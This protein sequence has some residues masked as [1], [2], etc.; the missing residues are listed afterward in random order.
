MC[1]LVVTLLFSWHHHIYASQPRKFC[2]Y[3]WINAGHRIIV[4]IAIN[5][6]SI[7]EL[8][9]TNR[10]HLKSVKG[11]QI[12]VCN[13]NNDQKW[14]RDPPPLHTPFH[15][16]VVIRYLC[17]VTKDC[18]KKTSSSSTQSNVGYTNLWSLVAIRARQYDGIFRLDDIKCI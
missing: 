7:Y 5:R 10:A 14:K 12:C 17:L 3:S 1:F 15:F 9:A 11:T 6:T 2:C 8:I 4:L 13:I 18:L 16:R